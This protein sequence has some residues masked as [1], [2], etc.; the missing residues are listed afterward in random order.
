MDYNRAININPE[1]A[2]SYFNR[3]VAKLLLYDDNGACVDLSKAGEMGMYKAYE[4]IREYC[5]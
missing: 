5:N 3:G 4:L 2:P 1:Y